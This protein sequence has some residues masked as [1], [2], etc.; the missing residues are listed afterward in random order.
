MLMLNSVWAD[1]LGKNCSCFYFSTLHWHTSICLLACSALF[2]IKRVIS[3][4]NSSPELIM[5]IIERRDITSTFIAPYM[6]QKILICDSKREIKC[7]KSILVG[8]ATLNEKLMEN[9]QKIFPNA[10]IKGIY[11]STESIIV[12][13][14]VEGKKFGSSGTL[15]DNIKIKVSLYFYFKIFN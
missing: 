2:D 14:D 1:P 8:G 6:I 12:A 10:V 15:V 11:G 5:D 7:L 3:S 9:L 13:V 4:Q